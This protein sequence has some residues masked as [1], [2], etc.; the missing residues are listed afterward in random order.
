MIQT[1]KLVVVMVVCMKFMMALSY[2]N[3]YRKLS[4][5]KDRSLSTSMYKCNINRGTFKVLKAYNYL[6][7]LYE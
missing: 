6:K 2:D 1:S 7:A 4:T 3:R 5:S